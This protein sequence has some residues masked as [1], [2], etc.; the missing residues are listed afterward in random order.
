MFNSGWSIPGNGLVLYCPRYYYSALKALN[1][2]PCTVFQ[3]IMGIHTFN[4][5][6]LS[7]RVCDGGHLC[8]RIWFHLLWFLHVAD[9]LKLPRRN[10]TPHKLPKTFTYHKLFYSCICLPFIIPPAL[11]LPPFPLK[12]HIYMLVLPLGLHVNWSRGAHSPTIFRG[13]ESTLS[14]IKERM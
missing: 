2:T 11:S 14:K 8:T 1:F 12:G 13:N 9:P 5:L 3:V 4:L 7:C 10:V 6:Q